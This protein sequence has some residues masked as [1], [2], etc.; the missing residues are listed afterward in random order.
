MI[1]RTI[2]STLRERAFQ[3][4]AIVVIGPR[5]TGKTTVLRKLAESLGDYLYLDGDDS[6]TRT[7]LTD[8]SFEKLKQ[9][10]G[11]YRIVFID[12]AQRIINGGLAMKMITDRFPD[13]Q[14]LV[15]GSSAL[16]LGDSINEPLTGRK[17]EFNMLPISWEEW[18]AH[19]DFL[20][21]NQQ[22]E[23]RLIFGMYP[24]VLN[25]VGNEMTVLKDLTSSYLYKDILA[26]AG[27]RKP[28][29]LQKLVQALSLQCGSEVSLNELAQ[30]LN[31]DKNT[32]SS[33]I[34]LLEKTFVIFTLPS[35]NRN[36]RNEIKHNR[37]VYFYDNGIRN[38][39]IGNFNPV[40]LRQDIGALWENF[41]ISERYKRLSNHKV[42]A[43][44]YFW[45]TTRQQEIDYIEESNG[46]FSAV[47][48]KW[49]PK[50]K[51]SL[52][53]PFAENY[54][55]TLNVFHRDNFTEFLIPSPT[56]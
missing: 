9:L 20:T 6:Q 52:P 24:D 30:L 45:R 18:Q 26:L 5:Q 8:V 42:Y 16:E 12:E 4:K 46:Q 2:F 31:I 15:S 36:V 53:K 35:L 29:V 40:H 14:L 3:G 25:Q 37:K 39:V 38:A 11:N 43:N 41:M 27:I 55:A 51:Q 13:V 23:L 49:N 7:Q 50:K 10:I 28:S 17:W 47:E 1:Q 32:V 19:N 34:D 44:R 56:K 33:Y 54:A 48:F 22:L 21:V